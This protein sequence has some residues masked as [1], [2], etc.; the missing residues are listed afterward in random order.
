MKEYATSGLSEKP[1]HEAPARKKK[2]SVRHTHIEHHDDN[3]HTVKRTM[4]DG[5]EGPS[6]GLPDLDA[7]HDNLEQ[8]LGEPNVGEAEAAGAV[9]APAPAAAPGV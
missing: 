9:P 3:T 1:K 4:D 5:T 6:S 8:H 7:V 2:H